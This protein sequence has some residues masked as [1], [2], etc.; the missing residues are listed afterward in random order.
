MASVKMRHLRKRP[1][2]GEGER[3]AAVWGTAFP[4]EGTASA[5]EH[6]LHE[7]GWAR[8]PVWLQWRDP[9]R[10][11]GGREETQKVLQVPQ[12][13]GNGLRPGRSES[14]A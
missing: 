9:G 7:Q 6:A 5:K 12:P 3:A 8:G 11:A 2:G 13:T 1:E 14:R 10:G 4:I